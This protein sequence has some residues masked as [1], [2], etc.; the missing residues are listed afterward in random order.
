MVRVIMASV[1]L[2]DAVVHCPLA[3]SHKLDSPLL[4]SQLRDE[5]LL[6]SRFGG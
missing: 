2:G 5:A 1:L 4:Q 3:L 6:L